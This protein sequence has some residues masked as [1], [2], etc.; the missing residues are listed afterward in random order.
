MEIKQNDIEKAVDYQLKQQQEEHDD[1]VDAI[2]TKVEKG[3]KLATCVTLMGGMLFASIFTHNQERIAN[4]RA[5]V[6]IQQ[7]T[8]NI[9]L[10]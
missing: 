5:A 8:S 1:K 7:D 9:V 10:E 3:A 6:A 2:L 4:E